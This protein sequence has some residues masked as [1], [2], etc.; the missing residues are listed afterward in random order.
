MTE[1]AVECAVAKREIRH[2]NSATRRF[3]RPGRAKDADRPCRLHIRPRFLPF[4]IQSELAGLWEESLPRLRLIRL[5]DVG[6]SFGRTCSF[7]EEAPHSHNGKRVAQE[8][9]HADVRLRW[10][11]CGSNA[12]FSQKCYVPGPLAGSIV[13][14]AGVRRVFPGRAREKITGVQLDAALRRKPCVPVGHGGRVGAFSPLA[15]Q[16]LCGEGRNTGG[17]V[18]PVG[19][20]HARST[21][22]ERWGIC[23]K[24]KS[25]QAFPREIF[26][27]KA[28]FHDSSVLRGIRI[29]SRVSVPVCYYIEYKF[30]ERKFNEW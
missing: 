8:A 18:R 7:H 21:C 6:R 2:A 14:D 11:G 22:E 29:H 5:H 4:P 24:R 20:H 10:A 27:S 3:A 9:A 30:N 1:N 26:A 17:K 23:R 25:E 19:N 16:V 28:P 15:V 12:L 13:F